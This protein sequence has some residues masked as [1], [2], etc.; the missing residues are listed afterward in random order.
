MNGRESL[1][2]AVKVPSW[3]QAQGEGGRR[4]HGPSERR[5]AQQL[6]K[7]ML[8]CCE[9]T[10]LVCIGIKVVLCPDIDDIVD[11]MEN[12]GTFLPGER[13]VGSMLYYVAAAYLSL[14]RERLPDRL[15]SP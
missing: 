2:E 6:E 1:W 13:R 8:E 9:W 3:G 7:R 14:G 11:D 10:L 5:T 12:P 4:C 15:D